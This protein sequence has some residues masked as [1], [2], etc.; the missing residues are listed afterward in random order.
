MQSARPSDIVHVQTLTFFSLNLTAPGDRSR[1]YRVPVYTDESKWEDEVARWTTPKRHKGSRELRRILLLYRDLR[2]LDR[3]NSLHPSV[4]LSIENR[5]SR[6]CI[7]LHAAGQTKIKTYTIIQHYWILTKLMIPYVSVC[8][9][10]LNKSKIPQNI[11]RVSIIIFELWN[12]CL[13]AVFK[14]TRSCC[15]SRSSVQKYNGHVA[16]MW[17][18]LSDLFEP[19]EL[20]TFLSHLESHRVKLCAVVL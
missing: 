2:M 6:G 9:H 17:T 10:K 16:S 18:L 3:V 14:S 13:G 5:K 7:G 19:A 11:Y 1:A 4:N 8:S 12:G 15:T 20:S